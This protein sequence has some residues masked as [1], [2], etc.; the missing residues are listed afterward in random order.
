MSWSLD[1]AGL[2]TRGLIPQAFLVFSNQD[3]GPK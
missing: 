2:T 1:S 3:V